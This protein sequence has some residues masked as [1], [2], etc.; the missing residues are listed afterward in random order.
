MPVPVAEVPTCATASGGQP[1][2]RVIHPNAQVHNEG[3]NVPICSLNS[4]AHDNLKMHLNE[5]LN[6]KIYST[7]KESFSHVNVYSI[8]EVLPKIDMYNNTIT[9]YI[10]DISLKYS[11]PLSYTHT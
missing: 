5:R 3:S 4:E 6:D 9:Q 10:E 7:F 8:K 2:R 11:V 1:T